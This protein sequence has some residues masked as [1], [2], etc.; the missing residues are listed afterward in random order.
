MCLILLTT[1][2]CT[3]TSS[4]SSGSLTLFSRDTTGYDGHAWSPDGRWLASESSDTTQITLFSADGQL[5]NELRFGCDLG[6][7]V[8]D[9]SWLPDGR[10][11]CFIGNEPPLLDIVALDQKGQVGKSTTI[12]VPINAGTLVYAIQG[13]PIT[14]GLQH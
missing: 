4:S 9:I 10:I 6:N 12:N 14:S 11:S 8:E 7:G 13:I 1:V 2:G 3:L 5:V